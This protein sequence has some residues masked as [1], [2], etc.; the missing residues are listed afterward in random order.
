[1]TIGFDN[2]APDQT[3]LGLW[4]GTIT[5]TQMPEPGRYRLLIE[6]FEYVSSTFLVEEGRR[7]EPPGRLIYAETFAMDDALVSET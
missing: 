2:F 7:T 3:S 1:V 4:A 6:E 5:F